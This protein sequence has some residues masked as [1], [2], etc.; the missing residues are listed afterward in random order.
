MSAKGGAG[1]CPNVEMERCRHGA[2][3][4]RLGTR[5]MR[6]PCSLARRR[7]LNNIV[8]HALGQ[9]ETPVPRFCGRMLK[10]GCIEHHG[11]WLEAS[12]RTAQADLGGYGMGRR[13]PLRP[14]RAAGDW[15]VAG[16]CKSAPGEGTPI[17]CE[18]ELPPAASADACGND[19]GR[20]IRTTVFVGR[21]PRHPPGTALAT[22]AGRRNPTWKS[23][24]PAGPTGVLKPSQ[25][26]LRLASPGFAIHRHL[27]A[28]T[29]ME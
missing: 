27:D 14:K 21:R 17:D 9:P 20:S 7:L 28:R 23:S 25:G 15:A 26:L 5:R 11:Q 6:L 4:P 3:K 29:P 16:S 19:G 12:I 24:G 1:D 18:F 2:R 10:A 22:L 8:K 13:R